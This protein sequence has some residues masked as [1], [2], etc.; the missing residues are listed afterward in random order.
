MEVY[1]TAY[2]LMQLA[3]LDKGDSCLIYAAAS[4]VGFALIQICNLNGIVPIAT[5]SKG[6]ISAV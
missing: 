1:L 6:K 2:L 3:K 4:G 5:C